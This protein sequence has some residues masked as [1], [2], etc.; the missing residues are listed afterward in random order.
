MG[1]PLGTSFDVAEASPI[2]SR[3]T[4]TGTVEN[5]NQIAVNGANRYEGLITYVTGN[6][7]LYVFQGGSPG[8]WEKIV[9]TNVDSITNL[10]TNFTFINSFN[11]QVLYVNSNQNITATL[12]SFGLPLSNLPNGYNVS[13]VQLGDGNI[14]FNNGG[15]NGGFF[16]NR[17]NLNITAGKYAVA[18]ILKLNSTEFLLYGDLA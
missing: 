8:T 9:T 1:V 18:S 3:M 12:P 5:L 17:F 13:V 11:G 2:D 14:I 10:T 4:W 6:Q 15:V 16:R 7:N